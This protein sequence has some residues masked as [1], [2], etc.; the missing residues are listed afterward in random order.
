[1]LGRRAREKLL[2]PYFRQD[3][4]E[5]L[6][7]VAGSALFYELCGGNVHDARRVREAFTD[8]VGNLS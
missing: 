7:T 6:L 4:L 8:F 2:A 3:Y 5:S 1:M